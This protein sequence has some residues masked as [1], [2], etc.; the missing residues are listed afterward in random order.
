VI[1]EENETQKF[2][3]AVAVSLQKRYWNLRHFM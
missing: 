1:K 3:D 2:L